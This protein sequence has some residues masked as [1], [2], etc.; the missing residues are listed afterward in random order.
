[1][2]RKAAAPFDLVIVHQP[3]IAMLAGCS[4]EL[5]GIPRVY[6]FHSSW[7]EEYDIRVG[8]RT[9]KGKTKLRRRVMRRL[10][11]AIEKRVLSGARRVIVLSEFMKRRL[12]EA[13]GPRVGIEV[14]PGGVDV[15]TFSPEYEPGTARRK[16]GLP[17]HVP[18]L[19]TV[20][21]LRRRMG[22]GNLLEALAAVKVEPPPLLVIVG[23]GELEAE[24]KRRASG[25]G[26]KGRVVFAGRVLEKR[27]PLYYQAA[28]L[29][30]LPTEQLE[31]FGMATAEALASGT[32]V[33]GTPVGAT[34]EL[35]GKIG[36]EW[37]TRDSSAGALAETIAERLRWM[38]DHPPAYREACRTCRE[39]AVREYA[40]PRVID[41]WEAVCR[42]AVGR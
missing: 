6:N 18:M 31:G 5:I 27:L 33:I 42:E 12:V 40:W 41:R 17:V 15:D 30:V 19:L 23:A 25:F 37:I 34:P 20:R 38:N 8:S 26:L 13:H 9:G 36:K 22:L 11:D 3:L 16:L 4:R 28:D 32:P 24:L 35:L 7:G 21:N 14:I 29:F 1:M 10:R 2:R 39:V